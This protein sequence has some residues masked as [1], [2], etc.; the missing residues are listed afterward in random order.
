[1]GWDGTRHLVIYQDKQSDRLR[2][3]FLSPAGQLDG[4]AFPI[5][6]NSPPYEWQRNPDLAWNGSN[7]LVVWERFED[8]I[9]NITCPGV[10][11]TPAGVLLSPS[12]AALG[13]EIKLG[14]KYS[15]RPRVAGSATEFLVV[16]WESSRIRG[17]R[18]TPE[19]V[20]LDNGQDDEGF[21]IEN[22]WLPAQVAWTGLEY[23]VVFRTVNDL[24]VARVS[25]QGRIIDRLHLPAPDRDYGATAAVVGGPGTESLLIYAK[26]DPVLDV[27]RLFARLGQTTYPNRQ[28]PAR[29]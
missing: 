21:L 2:G 24:E 9:C 17:Q 8:Y 6:L 26:V 14:P 29:P 7:Y 27:R 10:P 25:R 4:A 3:Q 13:P 12:G 16:T 20:V 18:V 15:G 22:A 28:R 11:G 23:Q 19:G 5:S 1:V